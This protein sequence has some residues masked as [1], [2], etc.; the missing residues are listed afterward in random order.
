M[1]KPPLSIRQILVWAD[2][3]HA[4]TGHWPTRRSGR[5]VGGLGL[6]WDAVDSA[7]HQGH[8]GLNRGGSLAKLL[9]EHRGHR[10]K[11]LLPHLKVN[12]ILKWAD[13]HRRRTGRWPARS[14][15]PVE[16]APGE[17]WSGVDR[18][19]HTRTRGLRK[20][21]SLAGLLSRRR[22]RPTQAEK[23]P[24]SEQQILNWAGAWRVLYGKWPSKDSGPVGETG[25]DWLGLDTALRHGYRGLRGGSSLARLLGGG[26]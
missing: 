12:T 6:T 15:G 19:L 8:R 11:R 4:R 23:P 10:H 21:D 26:R 22:G 2:D 13:A 24:L 20:I 9:A 1:P 18:A 25:E 7:A 16:D 3:F 5:I 17:T 14:S